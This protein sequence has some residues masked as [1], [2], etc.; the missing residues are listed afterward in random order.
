MRKLRKL[1]IVLQ[2]AALQVGPGE[3]AEGAQNAVHADLRYS[4]TH[5]GKG[6]D[7][8]PGRQPAHLFCFDFRLAASV[9]VEQFGSRVV[10]QSI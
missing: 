5:H 4:F 2:Q 6:E 10:V 9:E 1:A 8:Q 7:P 3:V